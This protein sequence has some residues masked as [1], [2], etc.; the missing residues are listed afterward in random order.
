[1]GLEVALGEK[2][3]RLIGGRDVRNRETV[4]FDLDAFLQTGEA[5]APFVLGPGLLIEQPDERREERRK[6]GREKT[7]FRLLHGKLLRSSLVSRHAT[8]RGR[9][10]ENASTVERKLRSGPD[11]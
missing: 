5:Q 9:G 11:R 1:M 3:V 2:E 8:T 4:P 10:L 7:A 6:H